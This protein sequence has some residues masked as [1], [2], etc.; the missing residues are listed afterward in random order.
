M[1]IIKAR[2]EFDES[3]I[4]NI[5]GYNDIGKSAITRALEIIFYDAYSTE[6]IN[7]IHDGKEYSGIGVEFD[8]GVAINKYKY[9]RVHSASGQ[10][11]WEMLQDGKVIY[12][13]RLTDG[14]ASMQGIP[15][16][17]SQYL[18]VVKDDQTGEKLN[19][20]R[21]TDKLFLI[22]T[23]G[24]DN[25]KIINTVL[26]SEILAD[27]VRRLNE[28]RNKLQSELASKVT[29]SQT[30]KGEL[31]N[32]VVL[33]EDMISSLRSDIESLKGNKLRLEYLLGT[34]SLE[35]EFRAVSVYD[36]L[37]TVDLNRIQEISS[38]IESKETVGV[39]IYDEIVPLSLDRLNLLS[40][41][42]KLRVDV[43]TITPPELSLVSGEK[44]RDIRTVGEAYNV[45]FDMVDKLQ[46]AEEEFNSVHAELHSLSV[47]YGFKVCKNCGSVVQ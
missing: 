6:Q 31:N 38:V 29:S 44:E 11:V 32:L 16:P 26:R 17:I 4:I 34:D 36:E 23:S 40:E 24:S 1:S 3:G 19:V 43:E 33:N 14:I 2:L 13:N 8:D 5:V 45:F 42:A 30:L 46:V 25:Y 18:G 12:T 9:S 37:S 47:Q 35:R 10:S 21:N 41:I 15:E 22:N 28:D 27:S 7:F 20:R 39:A